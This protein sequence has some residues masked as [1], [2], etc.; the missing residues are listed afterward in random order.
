M[1]S[2]LSISNY[3]LINSLDI[4]FPDGLIII[5]GET[6]AGKSI[7]LGAL[8]LVLG[9]RADAAVFSDNTRNCVVEAEFHDK[10]GGEYIL[11]RVITPSG[12]SRSFLNDE[13]VS[14]AELT[15]I[16]SKIIDIHEQHQ[17]LLLT[18]PDFRLS[19]IDHFAGTASLLDDYRKVYADYESKEAEVAVL[20][21]TIAEAERDAEYRQFQLG[22]LAEAA[23]V[24]D[25]MEALEQEQKAL[26]H[27]E[28]IRSGLDS[29]YSALNPEDM[30]VA[31]Q[32]KDA[33]A[34][35][36][37]C[38]SYNPELQGLVDRLESCRIEVSDIENEIET[39]SSGISVSPHRLAEVEE[40]M[41]LI[42]SLERKY[43]CRNVEELIALRDSLAASIDNTGLMQER[44]T[45]LKGELSALKKQMETLAGQLSGQRRSASSALSV[46]LQEAVRS[47][48]M[49]MAV[50]KAEV[51]PS[52]R[53]TS[54][55]GDSLEFKFS[56]NGASSLRDISKVASGGELS[57]VMLALKGLLAGY[58][59]MPTMI[60][61]EIDT[62]VSGRIADKM[63]DMIGSMGENM[64]IFAITHLP[65]IA[66]KKG[67]HYVVYKEFG[68]D[69][70]ASTNI[71][72]VEGEDR[73][74]EV[75][76][77]LS[78]SELTP[79]A[80]E[81]ARELLGN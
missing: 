44:L 19:I 80:L 2:R 7:L 79:A 41:S 4:T 33:A 32:L 3:A 18:S 59:S 1:L 46:K 40:R 37:R 61:D 57:R 24:P 74:R 77:M 69:G 31:G 60:F 58:T 73:V 26:A 48:E 14:L 23:L 35:L 11:R 67:T 76:R 13:P 16:S 36:S 47:L 78:G 6:G 38:V 65:Q 53:L 45:G 55:G 66:S 64:Q 54:T 43:G 75:A 71:R 21:K 17:H 56:A 81:N 25:E 28:D 5:T 62:G 12:R 27:A 72:R 30:S 70:K 68:E 50:F 39:V 63:G 51:I 34:R 10:D 8:S 42:Y 29:A 49:P 9:K 15:A 22:K 20:E 52:G